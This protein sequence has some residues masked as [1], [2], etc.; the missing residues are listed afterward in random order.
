MYRTYIDL[1]IK[2]YTK[3]YC[4]AIE[5]QNSVFNINKTNAITYSKLARKFRKYLPN[6]FT[7]F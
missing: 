2:C 6:S 5:T 7:K 1:N 3:Q 4:K